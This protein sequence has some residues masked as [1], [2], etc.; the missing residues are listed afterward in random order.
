M[1]PGNNLSIQSLNQDWCDKDVVM[2]HA[3]FQL[4]KDCVEK[5]DLLSGHIDWKAR[6]GP[7][8]LDSKSRIISVLLSS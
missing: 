3:C 1:T 2:L 7:N 6:G 4:L 8:H 5:E